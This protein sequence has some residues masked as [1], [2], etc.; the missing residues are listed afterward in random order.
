MCLG[1]RCE[2]PVNCLAF[3]EC[4]RSGV[5]DVNG[6]VYVCECV[7]ARAC[8][9]VYVR[10]CAACVCVCERVRMRTRVHVCMHVRVFVYLC[11]CP[12]YVLAVGWFVAPWASLFARPPS[13]VP[14]R[15][16]TLPL[17][18]LLSAL[19]LSDML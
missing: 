19:S 6:G 18:P 17:C 14:P 16:I 2:D 3:T 13:S 10:V 1:G 8:V 15:A 4:L 11:E 5:V 9:R 12:S 7:R